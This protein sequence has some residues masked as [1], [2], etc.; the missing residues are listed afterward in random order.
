MSVLIM[1]TRSLG[2][3]TLVARELIAKGHIIIALESIDK[4]KTVFDELHAEVKECEPL[5]I[6]QVKDATQY[7]GRIKQ[8]SFEKHQ[9]VTGFFERHGNGRHYRHG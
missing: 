8:D 9:D 5:P 2:I 7:K 4:A 3:T 6:L 1:K